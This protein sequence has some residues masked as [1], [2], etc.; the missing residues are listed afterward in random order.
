MGLLK[1]TEPNRHF[2]RVH[3][4]DSSLSGDGKL[5]FS[6]RVLPRSYVMGQIA[7]TAV[8]PVWLTSFQRMRPFFESLGGNL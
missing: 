5:F 7:M 6:W 1:I 3:I 2:T 4:Q 8:V